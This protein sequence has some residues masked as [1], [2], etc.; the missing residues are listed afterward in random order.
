MTDLMRGGFLILCG[1]AALFLL[2]LATETTELAQAAYAFGAI[3]FGLVGA[4]LLRG[5]GRPG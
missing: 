2:A 4:G 1:S 5:T 3:G